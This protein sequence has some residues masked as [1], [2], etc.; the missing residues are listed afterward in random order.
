MFR[1]FCVHAIG[2][3]ERTSRFEGW[4]LARADRVSCLV[5]FL[6]RALCGSGDGGAGNRLLLKIEPDGFT[7]PTNRSV[8][9][10]GSI[11]ARRAS[12]GEGALRLKSK[13]KKRHLV[14]ARGVRKYRK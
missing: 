1:T 14:A 11:G 12:R 4:R 10:A 13:K 7:A 8:D 9:P 3:Q 2:S 5:L 6:V